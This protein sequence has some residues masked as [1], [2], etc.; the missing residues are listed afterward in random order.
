MTEEGFVL[1]HCRKNCVK[2]TQDWSLLYEQL[3]QLF[4]DM[5]F[6]THLATK[7]SSVH[8]H[9]LPKIG[10]AGC[11]NACSQP[12]IKDIG[13]I[14]YLLPKFTDDHCTGCQACIRSCQEKA[15]TWQEGLVFNEELCLGCGDC[16]RTCKTGKIVSGESGWNLYLG[17]RLGRKPKLA[18]LSKEK[19]RSDKVYQ[20][21]G[22]LLEDYL[23]NCLPN[24]RLTHF[25]D[26]RTEL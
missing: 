15:L 25:L 22:L 5:N 1:E 11:P 4:Q 19:F 6:S 18:R 21:I 17:G 24:E 12:Q 26:R 23:E 8:Y 14:G 2:S 7:F 16:I 10:L 9:H 13:I 20:K 3:N